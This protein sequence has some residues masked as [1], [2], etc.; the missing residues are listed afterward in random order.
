MIKM[1]KELQEFIEEL[2][3][4]LKRPIY[5]IPV[6]SCSP[7]LDQDKKE[8]CSNC[9]LYNKIDDIAKKFKPKL[10]PTCGKE[11]ENER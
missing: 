8:L 9:K 6:C 5:Q 4:E 11:K 7:Y 2:K 10:C 1:T 3:R